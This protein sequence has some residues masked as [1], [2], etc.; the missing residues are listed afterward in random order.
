MCTVEADGQLA[1]GDAATQPMKP[2]VA[3]RAR[4]G[5]RAATRGQVLNTIPETAEPGT[6]VTARHPAPCPP[7]N[8]RNA[9]A[10]RSG[11]TRLAATR[12]DHSLQTPQPQLTH[13]PKPRLVVIKGRKYTPDA[14]E[15]ICIDNAPHLAVVIEAAIPA[16]LGLTKDGKRR[17]PIPLEGVTRKLRV[18][19]P[20]RAG[21]LSGLPTRRI[22]L[23]KDALVFHTSL[24]WEALNNLLEDAGQYCCD[25]SQLL[26]DELDLAAHYE[27]EKEYEKRMQKVWYRNE[28][29][30]PEKR[31]MPCVGFY[32]KPVMGKT[33]RLTATEMRQDLKTFKEGKAEM[34]A[35]ESEL[36]DRYARTLLEPFAAV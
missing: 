25:P 31:R 16:A 1:A 6:V 11:R 22:R 32:P 19:P 28:Y 18:Q 2:P 23:P 7:P 35:R 17:A 27:E 3:K 5:K 4:I 21:G 30:D 36:M 8:A 34:E 9:N 20:W 26:Q 24:N 29:S 12:L 33:E 14:L 13:T 10:R 15:Q